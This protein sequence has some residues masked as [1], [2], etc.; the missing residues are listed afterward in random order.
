M[1]LKIPQIN[2]QIIRGEV[3]LPI[4]IDRNRIDM[5]RMPVGVNLFGLGCDEG[6]GDDDFWEVDGWEEVGVD[7]CRGGVGG[8]IRGGR[9]GGG[10]ERCGGGQLSSRFRQSL[11]RLFIHLP[12]FNGFIYHMS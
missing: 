2:P 12:Q 10:S 3:R 1:T 9:E 4:G 7:G 6:V 11:D 5:V 8:W